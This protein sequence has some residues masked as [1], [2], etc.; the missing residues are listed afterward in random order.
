MPPVFV[1]RKQ[2]RSGKQVLTYLQLVENHRQDGKVRQKVLLT[3]GREDQMPPGR[4]DDFVRALGA[5]AE[6]ALVLDSM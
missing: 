4:V 3:V 6:K 2:V 5:H 1:R